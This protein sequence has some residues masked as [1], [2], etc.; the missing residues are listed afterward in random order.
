MKSNLIAQYIAGLGESHFAKAAEQM[1]RRPHLHSAI[2]QQFAGLITKLPPQYK[3]DADDIMQYARHGKYN[4]AFRICK[5]LNIAPP[6][7]V[8]NTEFDVSAFKNK[9]QD[10]EAAK[11]Q[12]QERQK[13]GIL[14]GTQQSQGENIPSDQEQNIPDKRK[15][16]ADLGPA[17]GQSEFPHAMAMSL[18]DE[19]KNTRG[20]PNKNQI[21]AFKSFLGITDGSLMIKGFAQRTNEL[22]RAFENGKAHR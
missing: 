9:V 21:D 17:P 10:N 15:L 14:T 13:E 2:V 11:Q 1:F 6:E 7:Q 22:S 20:W 8:N 12:K 19:F 3:S 18:L 5:E 16:P 4:E